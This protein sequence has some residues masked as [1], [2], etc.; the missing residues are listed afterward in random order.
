MMGL[1][2]CLRV[3]RLTLPRRFPPSVKDFGRLW[4]PWT[5][6][7]LLSRL[8]ESVSLF[9]ELAI[10]KLS[11]S[12][13]ELLLL[14]C[15]DGDF[16]IGKKSVKNTFGPFPLHEIVFN[17]SATCNNI[18]LKSSYFNGPAIIKCCSVDFILVKML[19]KIYLTKK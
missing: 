15:G 14:C 12:L 18:L 11:L 19:L 4:P 13:D 8:S 10:G 5:F 17:N 6:L 2:V 3:T 7:E 1:P 9:G 16:L